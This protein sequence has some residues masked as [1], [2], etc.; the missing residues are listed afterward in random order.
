MTSPETKCALV[1]GA[2]HRIG[3][4]IAVDLAAH[5]WSVAIHA[6]RSV[7]AAEALADA[8]RAEHG[9]ST[10]VIS[11]DLSK[12]EEVAGIVPAAA[13]ALGGLSLLVN[14]ASVFEEDAA[15][16]LTSERFRRQMM[17]NAE[18]PALLTAAFAAVAGQGLVVN[19][20]DQR[21]LKPTPRFLSY[22]ASKATLWWLTR[23]MAQA[24]APDV[25]V[26]A[27]GPGPT[28]K[29]AR[30][31]EADFAAM[32]EAV[33]LHRAPEIAEFGRTIRFL[34]EAPS[35]TGQM[36]ALDGGQHLAWA[37]PDAVVVE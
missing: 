3:R 21:V 5:G 2:A 14:N 34:W 4:A 17:V 24:L 30:Q 13:E 15:D 29:G 27:I 37:S 18:A 28:L 7:A 10:A 22:S 32:V 33:P 8:L 11:G 23:T 31:T 19:I 36:I 6:N 35:I 26:V 12:A 20:L 9:V 16:T 25:R 1:T